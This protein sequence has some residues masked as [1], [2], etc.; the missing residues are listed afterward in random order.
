MDLDPAERTDTADLHAEL[1]QLHDRLQRAEARLA[2]IGIPDIAQG[3]GSPLGDHQHPHATT[4]D[5]TVPEGITDDGDPEM[6]DRRGML[7]KAGTVVGIAAA[8]IVGAVT[9][10]SPAA[11]NDGDPLILGATTNHT[12]QQTRAYNDTTAGAHLFEFTDTT[13]GATLAEGAATLVGRAGYVPVGV[14][15]SSTANSSTAISAHA[16]GAASYGLRAVAT[17]IGSMAVYANG[18]TG[19]WV[20]SQT[21]AINASSDPST[22]TGVQVGPAHRGVL[23]DNATYPLAIPPNGAGTGA[24]VTTATT[25]DIYV[26]SEGTLYHCIAGGTAGTWRRLSG[27]ATAGAY[28]AI[29]PTRVYDSRLAAGAI[30]GSQTRLCKVAHG[31]DLTTG[32][33]NAYDVVPS[34]STAVQY[35]LTVTS[36]VGSGYLQ[37]APGTASAITS[38]SI[39]WSAT[40]QILANGLSVKID[41]NRQVKVFAGGGSTQFII[42]VLGY[43]L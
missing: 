20:D 6:T 3:A 27:P 29:T 5:V 26:D 2:A 31:I 10:A 18:S 42:D 28:T 4:P 17:G 38:S 7:A 22:G 19:I 30:S 21:V 23:I 24:P 11:A 13:G 41:T 39:N 37:V 40:G 9:T 25:G 35:N 43:Y 34:G 36:T 14:L 8:G 16:S 12:T 1:R 33:I 32:T 15:G